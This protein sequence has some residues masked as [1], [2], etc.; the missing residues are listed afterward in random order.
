MDSHKE[1]KSFLLNK[2]LS[3]SKLPSLSPLAVQIIELA[4]DEETSIDQLVQIIRQ[5]PTLTTRL[6]RL[7]NS[8]FF[9]LRQPVST[10]S[11]AV[12]LLGFNRVRLMALTISLRESFPLGKLGQM[13][14]E[15]CWRTALYRAT[16]AHNL[17]EMTSQDAEQAFI[18]A[19]ILEIGLFLMFNILPEDIKKN[20]PG[21]EVPLKELLQWEE[22][23]FGINH[24]QLAEEVL[25]VWHFPEQ[26]IACQR[27]PLPEGSSLLCHIVRLA[28]Q[29]VEMFWGNKTISYKWFQEVERILGIPQEKVSETISSVFEQVDALAQELKITMDKKRDILEIMERANLAISKLSLQLEEQLQEITAQVDINNIKGQEYEESVQLTLDAVA[30]EIRNPLMA[31]GG[32]ARRLSKVGESDPQIKNYTQVI[33]KEAAR[34]ENV[35]KDINSYLQPYSPKLETT[36]LRDFLSDLASYWKQRLN[37]QGVEIETSLSTEDVVA[38]VDRDALQKILN[39]LIE[40]AVGCIY[41]NQGRINICLEKRDDFA[42]ICICDNGRGYN[43]KVVKLL[44]KKPFADKTFNTGLGIPWMKKIIKAHKGK[45]IIE[46][47]EGKGSRIC[48][49]LPMALRNRAFQWN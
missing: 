35:L 1:V 10:I 9:G 11:R 4:S 43:E 26:I 31:L 32:F 30:H 40:N 33:M 47:Q 13:D 37:K 15:K 28:E 48:V 2:V 42:S 7:A 34:L 24:R 49:L 39:R 14:F 12:T 45:L 8:A 6:L 22:D 29:A 16:I 27:Y 20:F 36:N 18:A 41:P 21:N 25:K 5:D 38:S 19:L 23:H 46:S 3:S 17:A 44:V